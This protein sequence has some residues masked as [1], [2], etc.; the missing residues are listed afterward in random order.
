MKNDLV[1]NPELTAND[2]ATVHIKRIFNKGVREARIF[3]YNYLDVT[4]GKYGV[5]G[6]AHSIQNSYRSEIDAIE[7][8]VRRTVY[9]GFVVEA[10]NKIKAE[11]T[12][13]IL[14]PEVSPAPTWIKNT[15]TPEFREF[16][17]MVRSLNGNLP[18][19]N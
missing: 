11:A 4:S 16:N 19:P 3:Q 15:I 6:K 5:K 2:N 10:D 13:A 17:R 9:V 7:R 12:S 8:S 1:T 18:R 14:S